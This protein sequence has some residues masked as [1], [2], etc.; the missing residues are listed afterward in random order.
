MVQGAK[1]TVEESR[2]PYV[3]II[4][5]LPPPGPRLMMAEQYGREARDGGQ[6][7][8]PLRRALVSAGR[9]AA[10]AA[11]AQGALAV[12][13]YRLEN[14]KVPGQWAELAPAYIAAP[15]QDPFTKDS[16]VILRPTDNG[17]VVYSVGQ[18]GKDDGGMAGEGQPP[19]DY[20]FRVVRTVQTAK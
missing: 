8:P 7:M 11:A 14:G 20:V 6:R 12:E 4:K 18:N 3:Q 16:P 13:R 15:V 17:Y 10:R 19:L 5:L 2:L 9:L 1:Q